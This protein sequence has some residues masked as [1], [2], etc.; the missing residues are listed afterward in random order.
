MSQRASLASIVVGSLLLGFVGVGS[1]ESAAVRGPEAGSEYVA[2]PGD[3]GSGDLE[4]LRAG[5]TP[6]DGTGGPGTGRPP[7]EG[8]GVRDAK[9][10]SCAPGKN[11]GRTDIGVSATSIRLASTMVSDG[12]SA[13]LLGQSPTG[14]RAVVDQ[15]NARGGIC[16]RRVELILRNDSFDQRRGHQYLKA[17]A[18]D[19]NE[20][21]FALAVVPSAE[22]LGAA[23]RAGDIARAGIPVVGTDGMREEQY[24]EPWVWPVATAT[25]STMRTMASYGYSEKKARTFAIV[26]DSKYKFGKEGADAFAQ[27]VQASGGTLVKRVALNPDQPSYASEVDDFNRACGDG[28]CDMVALLLLPDTAQKWMSR[29]PVS[30]ARYNAGAQTL[31]T[32]AFAQSCANAAGAL[33]HGFAVWTGY[34]PPIDRYASIPDVAAYVDDVTAISPNADVRNQ[35]LEGAYL[36]MRLM[37]EALERV[38]PEVTRLR[39]RDVLDAMTYGNKITSGLTWRPGQHHANTRARSFSMVLAEGSF[40]GWRDEGTGWVQDPAFRKVG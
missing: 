10:L 34:N 16:G 4:D 19:P 33:C 6:S 2:D 22:G 29:K 32:D 27:Q 26:Y 40:L 25:V 13:S 17:W 9:G 1:I 37:I 5:D 18:T 28:A 30:G 8:D 38:G 36:G 21:I 14:M 7:G 12:N 11:G 24:Q 23:I 15:V 35:F 3:G 20:D 31:F 39:L